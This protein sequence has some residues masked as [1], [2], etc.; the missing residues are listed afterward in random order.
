MPGRFA[1]GCVEGIALAQN[2]FSGP[3]IAAALVG[4]GVSHVIWLPDSTLGAW[5]SALTGDG[6]FQ[7]LRV[8]REGEAWTIAAGLHLGGRRPIVVMQNT[9]F[10]ESGDAMRNVL[11]DLGLPLYAIVGYRS[12]LLANSSDSAR[13]YTEPV[14]RAWGLDHVLLDQPGQ[15]TAKLTEHYRACQAAFRPGIALIA[16]GRG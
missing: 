12:F 14:V 6:A 2:I 7:L 9:G 1:I 13:W 10:F 4:L 3:E 16:E 5:E 11:F 8:C 15:S